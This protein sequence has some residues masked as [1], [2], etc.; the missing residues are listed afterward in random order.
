MRRT[1][2]GWDSE[3]YSIRRYIPNVFSYKREIEGY[4]VIGKHNG[5]WETFKTLKEAREF[6]KAQQ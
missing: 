2:W 3:D 5:V 6:I 1:S 4:I